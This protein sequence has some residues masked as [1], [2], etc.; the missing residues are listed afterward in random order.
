MIVAPISLPD[1]LSLVAGLLLPDPLLLFGKLTLPGNFRYS[2]RSA[3]T[4]RTKLVV[5]SLCEFK[6]CNNCV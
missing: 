5:C 6:D 2:S 3:F 1:P 4:C